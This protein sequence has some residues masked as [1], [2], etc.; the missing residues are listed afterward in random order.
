MFK[1]FYNSAEQTGSTTVTILIDT[2]KI[3]IVLILYT[4]QCART[5]LSVKVQLLRNFLWI[6]FTMLPMTLMS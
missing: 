2:N 1:M 5:C 3:K 4:V 6:P